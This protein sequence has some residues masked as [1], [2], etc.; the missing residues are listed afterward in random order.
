MA[1]LVSIIVRSMGRPELAEAL[2]S[3]AR[4]RYHDIEV[5]LVAASGSEHPKPPAA[6]GR[7]E[8]VYVPGERRR[9][10]PVAANAGLD[11]ARGAYIGFLDD[12]DTLTPEH[13][14]GLVAALEA[15]PAH[16]LAFAAAVEVRP[17]GVTWHVGHMLIS[18]L[19][20]LEQCFFP[21][22][23]AL[24]RRELLAQCRFDETLDAAEDWDFWL[25]A[26]R[27]TEFL[28]VRQESAIYR[29]DRGRS[30]MSLE[31]A[32][33][34]DEA[35]RWNNTVLRKWA[36][37]RAAVAREV[38]A[39]YMMALGHLER[40]EIALAEAAVDDTL[41]AYPYHVGALRLRG[42][43]RAQRGDYEAA[44]SD[45]DLAAHCRPNDPELWFQLAE[46]WGRQRVPAKAQEFYRRVLAL[47]PMHV[48]AHSR[49]AELAHESRT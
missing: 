43:W 1:S 8:I 32:A 3:V 4:Q 6:A 31:N 17:G 22:C 28:F 36:G 34:G 37:E 25:Q 27:H 21:P 18:R 26:A 10:R 48:R 2:A 30:V 29:A 16:A 41:R 7:F 40:S 46:V 5:V 49:L 15:S 23:A 33:A 24:F 14:S 44:V 19:A 45:L 38:D 20:L 13:V 39:R 42:A 47:D 9:P 35:Q 11:A 12:D